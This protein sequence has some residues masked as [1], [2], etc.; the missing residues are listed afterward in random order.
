MSSWTILVSS[1]RD[2]VQ[3]ECPHKVMLVRDYLASPQLY[4]GQRPQLVNLARS[5]AYQSAGYYAS[6]LAEARG[7]RI[8]PNVQTMLELAH[9]GD[10]R[11]ALP[12]LEEALN[13]DL[14]KWPQGEA[15]PDRVLVALGEA[16]Y[17][18]FAKFAKLVFD[19][20]RAPLVEATL[21]AGAWCTI[22]RLRAVPIQRLS[23]SQR[24]F[25]LDRLVRHTRRRWQSPRPRKPA[26]WALGVLNNPRDEL[27]PSSTASLKR[28]ALVGERMGIEVEPI[29][30]QDLGRVA[31]FDALFIRETTSIDNHTYRFALR[32]EQENMPV[33]DDTISMIRCTNKIYL[34]EL[35]EAAKLPTPQS[36]V[37]AGTT[38][39]DRIEAA[40]GY[41]LVL[42]VPDSSFSRGV[43]KINDRQQFKSM[44]RSLFAKTDLLLAQAF[45]PTAFDW[46]IGVL[47]GKPIFCCQY[48]M[49]KNHWQIVNHQTGGRPDEG[50]FKTIAIERTPEAIVDVAVRAAARIGNGLYGVDVKENEQGIFIIE[51][52]DN[53]NMDHDV[54]G[55]VGKDEIW[56]QLLAWF[57]ARLEARL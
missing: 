18:G 50:R 29:Q 9:K 56:R 2:L 54:E 28:L 33:I 1:S 30:R 24:E 31:E 52:N 12:E 22:S 40:L 43:H 42:K 19:W 36:F 23:R 38:D 41:P 45:M 10:Y 49:A 21:Q 7:H 35:L 6:L 15:V 13:R 55:L 47:G 37:I 25:L 3:S 26:R 17:R 44:T 34:K 16:E 8:V 5:F 46:R 11:H 20:F 27:P 57:E 48:Q 14:R 51:V 53:P 32:A 4:E 39:L